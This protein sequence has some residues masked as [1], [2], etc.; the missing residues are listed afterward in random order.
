MSQPSPL[1]PPLSPP[2]PRKLKS[3]KEIII[4]TPKTSHNVLTL[5][6]EIED[7]L[8]SSGI[9]DMPSRLRII[10]LGKAA[11]NVFAECSLLLDE[12]TTLFGQ[13]CEVTRRKSATAK[14]IGTAK[15]LG[16]EDLIAAEEERDTVRKK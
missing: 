15:V 1:L 11:E 9:L 13:N 6:K 2:P 4:F 5:R 12:N 10:K 16:Y 3:S 7:S 14:V 8:V